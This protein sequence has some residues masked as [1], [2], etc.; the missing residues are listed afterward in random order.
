MDSGS[1]KCT[2]CGR[3]KDFFAFYTKGKGPQGQFR[4]ERICKDCK[5]AAR[6]RLRQSRVSAPE[7]AHESHQQNSIYPANDVEVVSEDRELSTDEFSTL[8][9]LVA[10]LVRWRDESGPL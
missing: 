9:D 5:R 2:T 4:R 3:E 6:L 7:P 1:Q 8:L 10:Q